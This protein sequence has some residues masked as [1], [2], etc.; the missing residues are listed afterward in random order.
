M[1]IHLIL[2]FDGTLAD[3]SLGIHYSFSHACSKF[4]LVSPP[5]NE[6]RRLIGPPVQLIV[7]NLFPHLD[8]VSLEKFCKAFRE[9][10]DIK[11]YRHSDWYPGV[12]ET[13]VKLAAHPG[14]C[15]SVVTNKPTRPTIE[16]LS[17]SNLLSLFDRVIGIDY[18]HQAKG[19][20]VF[21]SKVDA[22]RYTLFSS[23]SSL[24]Y[25]FYVGDTPSDQMACANCGIP[26]VAALYGFHHW[27]IELRPAFCLESFTSLFSLVLDPNFFAQV[28]NYDAK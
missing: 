25:C 20:T 8:S 26:F 28:G 1:E 18:L 16:L 10:Y 13:L 14:L 12:P 15:L 6:F 17:S 7:H 5:L 23:P 3:S 27:D 22:L 9:D 11:N 4:G 19:G 21:Q 24:A 2:D